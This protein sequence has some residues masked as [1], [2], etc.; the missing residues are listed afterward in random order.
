MD[1][2]KCKFALALVSMTL[3]LIFGS[4]PL[5]F[6]EQQNYAEQIRVTLNGHPLSFD[7]PPLIVNNRTMVPFRAIFEAFGAEVSWNEHLRQVTAVYH[8]NFMSTHISLT[9]DKYAAY[10][11]GTQHLLDS[12]P[13]IVSSRTLVPL[14]FISES[15]GA[16][17]E[18]DGI[19]RAVHITMNFAEQMRDADGGGGVIYFEQEE[20]EELFQA[21]QWHQ[22]HRNVLIGG[23]YFDRRGFAISETS[24][25]EK[26]AIRDRALEEVITPGMSEFD[27]IIAVHRWLVENVSYN[28]D[29]WSWERFER[30]GSP[31]NRDWVPVRYSSE[32]QLAWSAFV[33]GTTVCAGY[34]EALIYLLEPLGIESLYILGPMNNITET[35]HAWNLVR[36]GG[37]WY[38]IDPTWNR[39]YTGANRTPEVHYRW[40]MLSDATMRQMC[41]RTWDTNEF[42]SAV[43]DFPF[44]FNISA[45]LSNPQAGNVIVRSFDRAGNSV[46][47]P[48]TLRPGSR[49]TL[50]VDRIN[51]GFE[52]SHWEVVS[53]EISLQYPQSSWTNFMMPTSNVSLRAV[54]REIQ[55]FT[56]TTSSSNPQAGFAQASQTTN[57]RGAEWVNLTAN[58]NHGFEFSHWE[59]LSGNVQ[60]QNATLQSTQFQMPTGNV[61]VRAVFRE[62]QTFSV[63]VDSNNSQ[64]GLAEASQ[65]TNLSGTGWEQVILTAHPNHGFEFSHWEIIS[66][67]ISLHD[68]QSTWAD[69]VMPASN[70]SVRAIFNEIQTFTVTVTT[71]NPQAGFTEAS[72]T[73]DLLGTGWE[74]I[75]LNAHPNQG[76]EFSHWEVVSGGISLQDP[77]S[78]WSQFEMPASNVSIRAIFREIPTFTVTVSVNNQ[79][80]GVAEASQTTDLLGTGWELI[81]LSADPNH[82]FEFSHWEVLSGGINLH[83]PYSSWTQFEMPAQNVSVR[84]IFREIQT[85]TVTVTVNNS[86]FGFAEASQTS[87]LLGTG[88]EWITL[89]AHPNHGFEFSHWEVVS[90]GISLH[91]SHS[92]WTQFQMPAS[93]VSVRAVFI[94]MQGF[95]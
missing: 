7:V 3:I 48:S 16:D 35:W 39:G 5:V 71:N 57:L 18:W 25:R 63:I 45:S 41:T 82:G 67:G 72:Q 59:V 51:Q 87:D 61:S 8:A 32:H 30:T 10:A 69:F 90:G 76:F 75:H 1:T 83:D 95:Y 65:T 77:Y 4:T 26:I 49:V 40:F 37:N 29:V 58:P 74:W 27:M 89:N 56:V 23:V 79:Q 38:H 92:S 81:T 34:A 80:F 94:Q 14:R 9:I 54:F 22:Y 62:T 93:N 36:L 33:L 17:V 15:F 70:V 91:N 13:I 43:R 11:N 60:L 50:Q 2:K 53:G 20:L 84:A 68:P 73:T 85:F 28:R 46:A 47:N 12:P 42:P 44:S 19:A 6:A 31:W 64:A 24:Y 55:T 88:W 78:E 86:Q 52:F 66:G 21:G